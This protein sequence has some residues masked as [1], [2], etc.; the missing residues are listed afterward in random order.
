MDISDCYL[1][2][3]DSLIKALTNNAE[4]LER[5]S[6]SGC[7]EAITDKSVAALANL[8]NKKLHFVDFSYAKA[9]T[10]EG[11]TAFKDKTFPL[12]HLCVNGLSLV[13]GT[14]LQW[15]VLAGKETL[16]CYNGAF[17]D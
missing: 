9:L 13:S 16:Q 12:T 17:M 1:I 10:D 3:E 4:T 15:P 7:T 2:Q 6:A 8:E 14:G 11:L 5:L